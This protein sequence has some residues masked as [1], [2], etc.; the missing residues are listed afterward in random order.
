MTTVA[1]ARCPDYHRDSVRVAWEAALGHLGGLGQYVSRG[2]TVLL[3]P[4]LVTHGSPDSGIATH[5]AVVSEA[6]ARVCDLGARAVVGDSPAFGAAEDV[7]EVAGIGEVARRYGARV[8]DFRHRVVTMPA[9]GASV[10]RYRMSADVLEADAII[11]LPKLKAHR[12]MVMTA[13]IKNLYGCVPGKRKAVCHLTHGDDRAKFAR[14]ILEYV[15]QIRPTLTVVDAIVAMSRTG[16]RFGDPYPLGLLVASVDPVAV[17]R[18]LC[19]IVGLPPDDLPFIPV[20]RDLGI[21]ETDAERIAVAGVPVEDACVDDFTFPTL[22][23]V[24]FSPARL[25]RSAVKD[26]WSRRTAASL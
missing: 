25:L 17:D 7:A 9:E 2:D 1:I 5:P 13:G 3:K 14:L 15:R 16:P 6:L 22:I 10:R 26:F 4:N 11:N 8:V 24:T 12:Q 19:D 21:G 18:T 20:A 23:P